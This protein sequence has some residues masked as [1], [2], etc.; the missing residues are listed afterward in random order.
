MKLYNH[1]CIYDKRSRKQLSLEVS[2]DLP[3]HLW[4]CLWYLPKSGPIASRGLVGFLGS[5]ANPK[6]NRQ[7]LKG[8]APSFWRRAPHWA[9]P[10][11]ATYFCLAIFIL[12]FFPFL[13]WL[14]AE[15]EVGCHTT[16]CPSQMIFW[17]GIWEISE[18]LRVFFSF[19]LL[20]LG[21]THIYMKFEAADYGFHF[22]W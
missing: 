22:W 9:T 8:V 13:I 5:R 4:W 12:F 20:N 16:K 6:G 3:E 1:I 10:V 11:F 15:F 7:T 17:K 18:M 2:Y 19:F 21:D 14:A